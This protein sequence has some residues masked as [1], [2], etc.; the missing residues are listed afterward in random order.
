[1]LY[2]HVNSAALQAAENRNWIRC[3]RRNDNGRLI[4]FGGQVSPLR[5]P[6]VDIGRNDKSECAALE[7]TRISLYCAEIKFSQNLWFLRDP[8]QKEVACSFFT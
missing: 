4:T 6:T 2:K 7:M 1:M 8:G 5:P 3:F